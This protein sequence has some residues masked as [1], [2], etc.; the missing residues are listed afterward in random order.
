MSKRFMAGVTVAALPVVLAGV[1]GM[2]RAQATIEGKSL[3]LTTPAFVGSNQFYTGVCTIGPRS[4]DVYFTCW[5]LGFTS[6]APRLVLCQ[7][8]NSQNQWTNWPDQ[9][10]C[11]VIHADNLQNGRVF[12]KVRRLDTNGAGWGQN[13]QINLLVVN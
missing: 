12:V 9:F 5:N 10:G 8:R 7:T 11:Q 1:A 13:L 3:S 6:S 2:A 4:G